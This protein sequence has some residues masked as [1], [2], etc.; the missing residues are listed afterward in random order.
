MRLGP[1]CGGGARVCMCWDGRGACT[2][3]SIDYKFQ[4]V[5]SDISH[6][7]SDDCDIC[8]PM[9]IFYQK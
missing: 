9:Y 2:F 8:T 4:S 7:P 6:I 3:V 5:L 1:H